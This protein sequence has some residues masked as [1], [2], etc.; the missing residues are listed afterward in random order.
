MK[1]CLDEIESNTHKLPLSELANDIKMCQ[2]IAELLG[3]E[4]TSL[5]YARTEHHKARFDLIFLTN[6]HEYYLSFGQNGNI[7]FGTSGF[8]LKIP[9][10]IKICRLIDSKY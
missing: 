2:T 9:N 3:T 6:Q 8:A 7:G 4:K 1:S 5:T 10:C